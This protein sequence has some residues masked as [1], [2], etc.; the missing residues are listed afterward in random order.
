MRLAGTSRQPPYSPMAVRPTTIQIAIALACVITL[1]L[2]WGV[3]EAHYA[4]CTHSVEIIYGKAAADDGRNAEVT[5]IVSPARYEALKGC[6][7]LPF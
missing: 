6:S 3:G 7:R 4:N 5:R 1:L 2:A